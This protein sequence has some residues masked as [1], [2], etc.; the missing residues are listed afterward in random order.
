MALDMV[1]VMAALGYERFLV[2]GHDRGGRVAHRLCLDHPAAG[3]PAAVLDIVADPTLFGATDQALATGYYHWF[4]LIQPD[5]PAGAADRRRPAVLP[6]TQAGQ[7]SAAKNLAGWRRRRWPSTSAACRPRHDPREL[8]GLSRGG[9]DR[10]DARRGRP[11]RRIACPLLALWGEQGLM[12]RHFDVL[13]T[14]RE[15]AAGPVEGR[16]LPCGHFLAEEVPEPTGAELL[17]FFSG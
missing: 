14:W 15:K 17:H 12:H 13:A 1:E 10:S 2:A 3:H 8:R 9:H 5:A 6:A 7:W 16:A 11:G 4:F